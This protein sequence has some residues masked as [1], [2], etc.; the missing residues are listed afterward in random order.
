MLPNEAKGQ[1]H[2]N[3]VSTGCMQDVVGA[4]K[5]V[6]QQELCIIQ[7]KSSI[8]SRKTYYQVF[9]M[10]LYNILTLNKI[11]FTSIEQLQNSQGEKQP[12]CMAK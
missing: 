5:K 11:P 8:V 12:I 6:P 7:R 9:Q 2:V 1:N 10:S 4:Q 3:K